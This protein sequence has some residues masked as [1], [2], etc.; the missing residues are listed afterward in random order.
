VVAIC[1]IS[2]DLASPP[3]TAPSYNAEGQ[4]TAPVIL[5]AFLIGM[6][7]CEASLYIG[8]S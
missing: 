4:Y 3:V 7:C 8:S 2:I 5:F 6:Q 1:T